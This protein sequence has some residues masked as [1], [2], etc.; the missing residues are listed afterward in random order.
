MLRKSKVTLHQPLMITYELQQH[1]AWGKE[2][3]TDFAIQL[4]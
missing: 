3:K 2:I 1:V 4:S